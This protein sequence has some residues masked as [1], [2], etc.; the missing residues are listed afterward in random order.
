MT[1]SHSDRLL[2][3]LQRQT[4]G[5]FVN[6]VNLDN[7]LVLDRTDGDAPSSIAATGLGLA[8]YPVG[9]EHG[10]I[11]RADAVART[12]TCLRFFWNSHHGPERDATGYNGFYYHFL[13]MTTGRRAW[14]CEL[15]SVDTTFLLAGML[16]AAEYFT[17][18][19][20]DETEIRSLA[21]ALFARVDWQW[22]LDGGSTVSH[23]W[24]PERGFITYRWQGYS[25]ALLLYILGLGSPT[26][27]LTAENYT[28][29]TS[30]YRWKTIYGT[31]L[32]YS[33]S[34]F[35]HQLSH[36]W[37]DLR[38][39]QD[40]Y[41]RSKQ[42]D[43]F[44]NSRRATH[45][46]R[47]YAIRNPMKFAGYG[48]DCWGLSASDGPGWVVC[49]VDGVKR[50]FYNYVS[51]GVPF[52][53]DDGTIAPWAAVAS[54]PFAPDIVLPAIEA[55]HKM[56]LTESNPYGFK[57]SFNRTFPDKGG[58]S[59]GWVSVGHC[60]INQGPI[61]LMIENYRTELIWALMRKCPYLVKGLRR[62]QFAGGW[63]DDDVR[64]E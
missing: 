49:T 63:L 47:E 32:L 38:G 48:K 46:Q 36:I 7:G 57:A 13:D 35:I 18:D 8:A 28:A 15:S 59:V 42:S 20:P 56:R 45:L 33:G 31:E 17:L 1:T 25:E 16:T 30:T 52:G 5:Y 4:F 6:E 60:G 39:I 27:P 22:M 24:K 55:F 21:H 29:W 44:E 3:T 12:L 10:F 62:A 51:R 2:N 64:A 54:L 23:G 14:K 58:G 9:V 43:Y 61:V 50:R 41:M 26:H 34:L 11:S 19:T 37:M 40:P 53:P